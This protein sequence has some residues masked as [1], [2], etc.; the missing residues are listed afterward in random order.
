MLAG[1]RH[2][3][4]A[5][6]WKK[7]EPIWDLLIRTKRAGMALPVLETV[8]SEFGRRSAARCPAD[9]RPDAHGGD[10]VA[11]G[12]IPAGEATPQGSPRPPVIV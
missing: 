12:R 11:D 4:Y 8:L 9:Y 7:F 10:P 1:L 5:A 2:A 3:A 6:G